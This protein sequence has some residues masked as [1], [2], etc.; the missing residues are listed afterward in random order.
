VAQ[1]QRGQGDRGPYVDELAA[2]HGCTSAPR[3]EPRPRNTA[4]EQRRVGAIVTISVVDAGQLGGQGQ[5]RA[6]VG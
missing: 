6:E 4:R 1:T 5:V 3:L 2:Q